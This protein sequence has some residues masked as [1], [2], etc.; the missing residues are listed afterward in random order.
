MAPTWGFRSTGLFTEDRGANLLDSGAHFYDVYETADGEFMSV[1]AIEPQFYAELLRGIGLD[2]ADLPRQMDKASWPAL[3]ER[4]AAIFKGKTRAEWCAIF[5][6]T[7][8]CVAPVLTMTDATTNEHVV[9][10]GTIVVDD[11]IAQPAPAPRFSRTPGAIQGP[12][13]PLGADT[14][15]TLADWGFSATRDRAA[16][17]RGRDRAGP[18]FSLRRAR[19]RARTRAMSCVAV[20]VVADDRHVPELAAGPRG[21]AVVVEVRTGHRQH[22]APVGERADAVHHHARAAR[23]RR[24]E[25]EPQHRAEMVLELARLRAFDRPVPGVVHAGRD[26]VREQVAADVEQLDRE[27]PDVVE[28]GEES[29]RDG[30]AARLQ[31]VVEA[32]RRCVAHAEDAVGVLVLDERPARDGAVGAAH[33][34]HGE[35]AVEG[36][37]LLEDARHRAD[38]VPRAL[39]VGRVAQH[40]LALAVVPAA[41]G[42]E[43]RGQPADGVERRGELVGRV[44]RRERGSGDPE[45]AERLLLDQPVLRDLE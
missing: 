5:D 43:H 20:A 8:A 3:K 36:E 1:G 14:D 38:G 26:L 29:G 16:P 18:A 31:R 24:A 33:R 17:R 2:G 27:H 22:R 13:P 15:A 35:L 42:L 45:R 37:E 34:E 21:L 40:P 6:G 10:R 28:L 7:D 9:A 44:D 32:G 23:R 25:G 39:D 11:G 19:G 4:F 41:P 12:T 30:R